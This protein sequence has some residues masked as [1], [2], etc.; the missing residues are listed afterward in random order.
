MIKKIFQGFALS[1]SMLTTLPFFRVH[2][3]YKG[4]NG[5]AVM[6][7]PLIG[8]LLG[9]ILYGTFS[10]LELY[11]SKMHAA[12]LVFA[13]WVILTGALHLDGLS[14]TIDGLFVKKERALEVMKDPHT[15][16]MG[17][18]FTVVFLLLKVATL[19]AL[20]AFYLLPLV[21]MLGRFNAVLAIYN[22]PY[23]SPNG[24]SALAKEEFTTAQF[25]FACLYVLVLSMLFSL[26]LLFCS[27]FVLFLIKLF[28][29]RRYGG[30]SGDIYGFTI[31]LSE[32]ILLNIIVIGYIR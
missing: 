13:L 4:I 6:F 9:L 27:L 24:M 18:I 23:I 25:L 14:D 16:G 17:M 19:I 5:Y 15:G 20:D 28:F 31:E 3:F 21:L 10:L 8:F 32:L 11:T 1:V 22:Y 2:D 12:V 29:M 7:Y 30:F 26:S